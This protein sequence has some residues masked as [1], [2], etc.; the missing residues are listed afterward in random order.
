MLRHHMLAFHKLVTSHNSM[1]VR[2]KDLWRVLPYPLFA[3]VHLKNFLQC[4]CVLHPE[5]ICE[6]EFGRSPGASKLH[7]VCQFFSDA[8]CFQV[9]K[10]RQLHGCMMLGVL[11]DLLNLFRHR[12]CTIFNLTTDLPSLLHLFLFVFLQSHAVEANVAVWPVPSR[13]QGWQGRVFAWGCTLDNIR[14]PQEPR[15]FYISVNQ[16]WTCE[17]VLNLSQ[18]TWAHNAIDT[19]GWW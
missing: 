5:N 17:S 4:Y 3:R 13:S 18:L 19:I 1:A 14:V 6:F 9:S 2:W 12:S 16:C 15:R 11:R 8:T 7:R 10:Q